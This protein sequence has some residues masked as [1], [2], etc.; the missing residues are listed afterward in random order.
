[1]NNFSNIKAPK[2]IVGRLQS[3]NFGNIIFALF[4]LRRLTEI[5]SALNV[6]IASNYSESKRGE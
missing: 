1:M 3:T 2:E 4:G 6:D 5:V